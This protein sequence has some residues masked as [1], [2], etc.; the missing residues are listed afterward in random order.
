MALKHTLKF[1]FRSGVQRYLHFSTR[2]ALI[3]GAA[4]AGLCAVAYS[5]GWVYVTRNAAA[6]QLSEIQ[7]ENNALRA[8]NRDLEASLQSLTGRVEDFEDRTEQ[9]ALIA[10]VDLHDD[11]LSVG[12]GGSDSLSDFTVDVERRFADLEEALRERRQRLSSTPSLRPVKGLITSSYGGRRDPITGSPARHPGIDIGARPGRPVV[13]TADGVVT[14]AGRIGAL[15][16]AI[17]VS[18][19]YGMTTRYGHLSKFIVEPGQRV[20]RGEVIGYVGRTGRA[21]G[22]HLHYEVRLH[23]QAMN[24]LDYMLADYESAS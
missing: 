10:G 19:G 15:G 21:T 4:L 2:Q 5:V 23:G 8:E 3:W 14:R 1:E 22:Y 9:L 12:I 17:Y 7:A 18:H 20:E 13:A 24:P 6:F 16:K 11:P